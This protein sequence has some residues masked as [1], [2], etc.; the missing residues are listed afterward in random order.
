MKA[1]HPALMMFQ[2]KAGKTF[3][4]IT[5]AVLVSGLTYF[6]FKKQIKGF[7][8]NLKDKRDAKAELKEYEDALKQTGEKA[9]LKTSDFERLS[10]RLRT[11]FAGCGT[12]NADIESVFHQLHNEADVLTLITT[13]GIRRYDAC[14]WEFDLGDKEL[15]LQEA[16]YDENVEIGDINSILSKKGID[17]KF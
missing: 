4:I 14:N 12:R 3:L 8:N 5:G 11:A 9:S 6:I 7:L 13:Y 2:S 16:M 1:T 17:F 15:T 10:D